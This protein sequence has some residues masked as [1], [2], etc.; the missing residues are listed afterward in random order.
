MLIS[1]TLKNE[2]EKQVLPFQSSLLKKLVGEYGAYAVKFVN[3]K[4]AIHYTTANPLK[5]SDVPALTWGTATYVTPLVFPL[6]SALY[7]R[8][9]LVTDYDP[10]SW[11]IFDATIPSNRMLY[12]KWVQL[13]PAFEID[14]KSTRL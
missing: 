1:A 10:T 9:G 7:G 3:S 11:K 14:R 4:W 6:S 2:I 13:Q 12:L 5:I 8:I